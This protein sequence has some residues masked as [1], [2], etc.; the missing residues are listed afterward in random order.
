[1]TCMY[2][3]FGAAL[4]LLVVSIYFLVAASGPADSRATELAKPHVVSAFVGLGTSVADFGI[5]WAICAMHVSWPSRRYVTWKG[6]F[7]FAL[8]LLLGISSCSSCFIPTGA[9][10]PW[11]VIPTYL[12][13]LAMAG[14]LLWN[15]GKNGGNRRE[16]F[17]K[18]APDHPD[19]VNTEAPGSDAAGTNT[20]AVT[21]HQGAA[22]TRATAPGAVNGTGPT[23][24]NAELIFH[25][26]NNSETV[27]DHH[28]KDTD[29]LLSAGPTPA[30]KGD[31]D[32][33]VFLRRR[34]LALRLHR[35]M[36]YQPP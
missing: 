32:D 13:M 16:W 8:F 2:L 26:L 3:G 17:F 27:F 10:V 15:G 30:K 5:F 12:V 4:L 14:L 18:T 33:V 19:A 23:V 22:A 21:T 31:G 29:H 28:A 25:V 7:V 35:A 36:A 1:V 11:V 20:D 24:K 9:W 34:L 6:A